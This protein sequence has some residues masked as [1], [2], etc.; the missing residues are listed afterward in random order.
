MTP[1]PLKPWAKNLVVDF[2]ESGKKIQRRK[3]LLHFE[4]CT[5]VVN[6]KW[7]RGTVNAGPR[8]ALVATPRRSGCA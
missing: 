2:V 3:M 1:G 5:V 6:M 8:F 4:N 7:N